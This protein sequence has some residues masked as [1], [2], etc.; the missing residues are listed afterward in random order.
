MDLD[1]KI[2]LCM[3]AVVSLVIKH[4]LSPNIWPPTCLDTTPP[5]TS[6]TISVIYLN[7]AVDVVACVLCSFKMTFVRHVSINGAFDL[8]CFIRHSLNMPPP[9]MYPPLCL[10]PTVLHI[11]TMPISGRWP[12]IAFCQNVPPAHSASMAMFPCSAVSEFLQLRLYINPG[13]SLL[14]SGGG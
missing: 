14:G 5:A 9:L 11:G 10:G 2:P 13:S 1:P 4:I 6:L 7:P 8:A 3:N 12:F